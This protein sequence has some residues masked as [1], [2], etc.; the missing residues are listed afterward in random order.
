MAEII[1]MVVLWFCMT[2]YSWA[3]IKEFRKTERRYEEVIQNQKKLTE[4]YFRYIY[5][6]YDCIDNKLNRIEDKL[7]S[8]K[9]CEFIA[10]KIKSRLID[11]KEEEEKITKSKNCVEKS[12]G[13]ITPTSSPQE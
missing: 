5:D 1:I 7:F 11:V 10:Q 9:R 12:T 8:D 3:I 6:Q 13:E 4:K 2:I